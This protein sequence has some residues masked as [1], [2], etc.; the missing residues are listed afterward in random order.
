MFDERSRGERGIL[1]FF[2]LP[3]LQLHLVRRPVEDCE[4]KRLGE[5]I[6]FLLIE[7]SF[8]VSPLSLFV[9]PTPALV[10]LSLHP[11]P[12][13]LELESKTLCQKSLN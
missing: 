12:R 5:N 6:I 9:F 4:G 3:L 13:K 8:E 1:V 2:L 7:Q 10:A 11:P